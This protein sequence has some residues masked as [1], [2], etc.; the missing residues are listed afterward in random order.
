MWAE[1]TPFLLLSFKCSGFSWTSSR[2]MVWGIQGCSRISFP[3]HSSHPLLSLHYASYNMTNSVASPALTLWAQPES[4]ELLL[5]ALDFLIPSSALS[6]TITH[7][8]TLFLAGMFCSLP[9]LGSRTLSELGFLNLSVLP[10]GSGGSQSQLYSLGSRSGGRPSFEKQLLAGDVG[11][12]R[13]LWSPLS[14][15]SVLS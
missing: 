8:E 4:S 10:Q 9:P 12:P 14:T 1:L 3:A 11:D 6:S 15:P 5:P 7:S 2:D 13:A